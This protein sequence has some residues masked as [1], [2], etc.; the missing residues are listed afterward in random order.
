MYTVAR[1]ARRS[2]RCCRTLD[3]IVALRADT[4]ELAAAVTAGARDDPRRHA[5]VQG[6]AGPARRADHRSCSSSDLQVKGL[7][8]LLLDF[9]AEFDGV[10][11]LLCWL[12]GDREL[13]WY[14]RTGSRLRRP[15]ADPGGH[16]P[17]RASAALVQGGP[18]EGVEE[19]VRRLGSR[20]RQPLGLLA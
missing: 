7:A 10:P 20:G 14:H 18:H 9:P 3:E 11:V 5:G 8:P 2:L 4:A 15:P 17:A 16:E 12:E 6:G 19:P 13:A 1:L